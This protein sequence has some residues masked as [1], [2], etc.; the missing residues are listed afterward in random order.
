M[1]R[2]KI[3]LT[4]M[5]LIVCS[6]VCLITLVFSLFAKSWIIAITSGSMTVILEVIINHLKEKNHIRD[7]EDWNY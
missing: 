2:V 6:F 1:K 7:I 4:I 3:K 5:F